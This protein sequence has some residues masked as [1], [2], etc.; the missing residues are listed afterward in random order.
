MPGSRT[1]ISSLALLVVAGGVGFTAFAVST[2]AGAPSSSL[3]LHVA[4]NGST[5]TCLGPGSAACPTLRAAVGV[6]VATTDTAVTID[7]ERGTYTDG[8]TPIPP[9]PASDTLAIVGSDGAADTILSGGGGDAATITVA[10]GKVSIAGVTLRDGLTTTATDGGGLTVNRGTVS[11]SDSVITANKANYGAGVYLAAGTLTITRSTVS[12]NTAAYYGG[13]VYAVSGSH[14][15]V[16]SSTINANLAQDGGGF[17]SAALTFSLANSTVTGNV[18][19]GGG[20]GAN[21]YLQGGI[22]TQRVQNDVTV[23]SSTISAPSPTSSGIAV[24][25]NAVLGT[26]LTMTGSIVSNSACILPGGG[27]LPAVSQGSYNVESD[28]SCGLTADTNVVNSSTIGVTSTLAANGSTGPQTLAITSTSSARNVVPSTSCP[29]TDERGTSRAG[30]TCDAGAYEWDAATVPAPVAANLSLT[31]TG[32][33]VSADVLAASQTFGYPATITIT[34]QPSHGT[35][36]LSGGTIT[37][38]P[39]AGYGGPDVIGYQLTTAGGSSTGTVSITVSVP[40]APAPDRAVTFGADSSYGTAVDIDVLGNDNA[41]Q[42]GTLSIVGLT[43]PAHGLAYVRDG[44]VVYVPR[45][46]FYGTDTFTYQAKT[47][48]G[49]SAPATVSVLVQH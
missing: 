1:L 21:M 36:T 9:V 47:T 13:G 29:A 26:N 19:R 16:Q 14:L 33:P 17:F 34:R 42:G 43:T 2:P 46:G 22:P 31:S 5:T 18:V 10:G 8:S 40:P 32:G 15:S 30:A 6:A 39:F 35:A 20:Q 44:L 3:T 38:K 37:Y 11:V 25:L 48:A 4:T 23:S 27:A 24:Y 7:I 12:A 41:L 49:T 28:D 45:A